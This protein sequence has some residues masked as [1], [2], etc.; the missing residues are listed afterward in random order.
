[1][2]KDVIYNTQAKIDTTKQTINSLKI[3]RKVGGV[4]FSLL[5]VKINL[6]GAMAAIT[7][8]YIS[9]SYKGI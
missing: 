9:N 6:I 7:V 4:S 3:V 8:F 2:H 5:K 1:M